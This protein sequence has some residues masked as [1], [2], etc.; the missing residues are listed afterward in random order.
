MSE[1]H[2]VLHNNPDQFNST[3]V[4]KIRQWGNRTV[5]P[6]MIAGAAAEDE[7]ENDHQVLYTPA[8]ATRD[9]AMEDTGPPDLL[10]MVPDNALVRMSEVSLVDY[11]YQPAEAEH[12][13]AK[14]CLREDII[15]LAHNTTTPHATLN[16][17]IAKVKEQVWFK[18]IEEACKSH[19]DTCAIYVLSVSRYAW[20]AGASMMRYAAQSASG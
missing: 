19:V 18:G 15:W 4:N 17:T 11:P 16:T 8:T 5:F 12:D 6:L 10:L 3:T 14:W 7:G 20:F 9:V 2:S 13:Y 1:I